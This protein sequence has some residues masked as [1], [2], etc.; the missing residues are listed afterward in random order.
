MVVSVGCPYADSV[1][2]CGDGRKIV[3]ADHRVVQSIRRELFTICSQVFPRIHPCVQ[4]GVGLCP[5]LEID[6]PAFFLGHRPLCSPGGLIDTGNHA[7]C[8]DVAVF[9]PL[10]VYRQIGAVTCPFRGSTAHGMKDFIQIIHGQSADVDQHADY[11]PSSFRPLTG[12][13]KHWRQD[14]DRLPGFIIVRERS[15]AGV[16]NAVHQQHFERGI[17][18]GAV[19]GRG[20]FACRKV[21]GLGIAQRFDASHNLFFIAITYVIGSVH[22][23]PICIGP[24]HVEKCVC[25]QK[26]EQSGAHCY[27]CRNAAPFPKLSDAFHHDPPNRYPLP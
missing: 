24:Q 14:G 21:R 6:T 2:L 4:Q 26:Q 17:A 23:P 13:E 12:D 10:A 25:C 11:I 3:G 20:G 16:L 1:D 27:L 19:G 7:V 22:R 5:L 18:F 15:R 9:I 8:F